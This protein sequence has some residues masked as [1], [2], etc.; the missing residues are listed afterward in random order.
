MGQGIARALA[1][2]TLTSRAEL[3][4]QTKFTGPQGQDRSVEEGG[5]GCPYDHADPLEKQ[6][7]DSVEASFLNLFGSSGGNS[8]GGGGS[9]SE[10]G[11]EQQEQPYID[12]LVLHSPLPTYSQTFEAWRVLETYVPHRI[13]HLGIANAPFDLVERLYRET[14]TSTTPSS[15]NSSSGLSIAPSVVQNRFYAATGYDTDTRKFCR[16]KGIVYQSFW[17]LTA[18]NVD[19]RM[20]GKLNLVSSKPVLRLR[21]AVGGGSSDGVGEISKEAA[22]YSLVLGLRGITILDGTTS[23]SH[24][25]EDLTGIEAVGRFAGSAEGKGAWEACLDEFKTFIGEEEDDD[26]Y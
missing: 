22:Y 4:L 7:R 17:T 23:E 3:F 5:K 21:D 12:S 8:N 11:E 26:N 24:M 19:D 10:G 6:V 13:R 20:R 15:S 16:E 9:A 1:D 2:G 25:R 18:N 14:T